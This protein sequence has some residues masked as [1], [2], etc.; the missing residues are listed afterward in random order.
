[1]LH[2]RAS[3]LTRSNPLTDSAHEPAHQTMRARYFSRLLI[4][5]A[6]ASQAGDR[7]L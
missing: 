3:T 2:F 5:R 7:V 6:A 1:M 4:A